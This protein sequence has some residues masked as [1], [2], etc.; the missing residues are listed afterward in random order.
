MPFQILKPTGDLLADAMV[1]HMKKED[2]PELDCDIA[3]Q[4]QRARFDRD[5]SQ[6]GFCSHIDDAISQMFP[7]LRELHVSPRSQRGL[8]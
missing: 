4:K 1:H 8:A 7:E 2:W 5:F 6:R 3:Y